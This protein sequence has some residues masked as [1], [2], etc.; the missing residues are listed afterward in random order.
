MRN[1]AKVFYFTQKTKFGWG[2]G[3]SHFG[4]FLVTQLHLCKWNCN[5]A[6]QAFLNRARTWTV[7]Q[8]RIACCSCYRYLQY[9]VFCFSCNFIHCC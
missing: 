4:S 9:F 5:D 2:L 7:G 8:R 6:M 3:H 1:K